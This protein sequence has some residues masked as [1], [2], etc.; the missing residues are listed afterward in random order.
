MQWFLTLILFLWFSLICCNK[1]ALN[2]H[3]SFRVVVC[4]VIILNAYRYSI[5]F[6]NN[7]VKTLQS[8]KEKLVKQTY[9]SIQRLHWLMKRDEKVCCDC[10]K[11]YSLF[12]VIVRKT[13]FPLCPIILINLWSVLTNERCQII[14][15]NPNNNIYF[16][17]CFRFNNKR[18]LFSTFFRTKKELDSFLFFPF[19]QNS[20]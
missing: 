6:L 1:L 20:F 4:F 13:Y 11:Q 2:H 5:L 15:T 10:K 9:F 7:N 8:I 17:Y 16:R 12:W 19:D 3:L 18:C 14:K